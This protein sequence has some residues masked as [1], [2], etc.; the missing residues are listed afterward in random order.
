MQMT[1]NLVYM[2]KF[3]PLCTTKNGNNAEQM[4]I[5]LGCPNGSFGSFPAFRQW[6]LSANSGHSDLNVFV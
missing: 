1:H 3:V 5:Y 2:G 4:E 6:L